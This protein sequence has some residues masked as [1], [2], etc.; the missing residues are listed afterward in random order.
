MRIKELKI[1]GYKNLEIKLVHDSDI[2]AL[3]GKNGSGKSN[4]LE[5]L[6]FIFK[7]LYNPKESVWF[8]YTIEYQNT[9]NQTIRIEKEKSKILY[10]L[11]SKAQVSIND[12]LPKKLVAIYSGEE[13]RLWKKY[14]QPI[15]DDFI[16]KINKTETK[17]LALSQIM[18]QMLYLNKHYWHLSLL[19]LALSDAPDNIKFV[20]EVLGINQIDKIKFDFKKDNYK[21][22]SNSLVMDFIRS[23]DGKSE[24][25]LEEL[26]EVLA[27][28]AFIPD[29]VYKYL[30]IAF[31]P[32]SSKILDDITIKF[33]E[34][35][36]IEDL[37]EG[38]KKLLLVKAAFEFAEQEDSLFILDEPDAHVH[39]NNKSQIVKAFEPYKDNRQIVITTHS[40]TITQSLGRNNLYM[41]DSGRGVDKKKEAII[42][43][44]AGEIWNKHQ[45]NI[46]L[47]SGKPITLFVE[48][49]HDKIHI[50]KAF[51][52]LCEDYPDLNFDVFNMH[53]A[54]NIPQIIT[55]LRTSDIEH[56]KLFIGV[57]DND[58]EG[59]D[60][61][62]K[63]QVKFSG[64]AKLVKKGF[65]SFCYPK[66]STYKNSN[67]TIENLFDSKHYQQAYNEIV[68]EYLFENKSIED[69]ST[70]IKEKV[71][72]RLTEITNNLINPAE[73][74]NFKPLFGKINEIW[75]LYNGNNSETTQNKDSSEASNPTETP[76]NPEPLATTPLAEFY[77]NRDKISAK[78]IYNPENESIILSKGSQALKKTS[79]LS[80]DQILGRN[81]MIS[82][83]NMK[84]EG[85]YF[86]ATQDIK[87]GSPSAAA[88]FVLGGSRNG[89]QYWKNEE[90]K[91]L[92]Q[93]YRSST[94]KV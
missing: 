9:N 11:N 15:Y 25:T 6:S 88:S 60:C 32:K 3:I 78:G 48:G 87:F 35:L 27:N 52:V 49:Q 4:L 17:G 62:N 1:E 74:E 63:T 54:S 69:I 23:I 81:K 10:Y 43:D 18:P 70:D 16:N 19:T 45:Q 94:I 79:S 93:I 12:Y 20:K 71:K 29:D 75:G 80:P 55:G 7:S 30:Y 8:D 65:V 37:S 5:A 38:E 31:T 59:V 22:Y 21:N 50:E 67:L 46:F 83:N 39:L 2:I 14:Y 86:V 34:H 56:N 92:S 26:K 68:S 76:N 40:P 82:D 47:T 41:L 77:I 72:G 57:F 28:K 61:C 42:E 89:W 84:D 33:N 91:S 13:D 44:L 64:N 58:A 66:P 51:D 90:N 36:T 85:E 73:F 53:G 24:Y